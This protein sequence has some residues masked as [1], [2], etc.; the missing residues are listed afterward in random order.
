M[1]II[2]L[3]LFVLFISGLAVVPSL[4][5][6]E[7]SGLFSPALVGTSTTNYYFAKPNELTITVDVLGFVQRPGRYEISNSVNLVNLLSLAG[8]A[9]TD[10]TLN[11]V[12][13]TRLVEADGKTATVEI[14][15]NLNEISKLRATDLVLHH[16]DVIQLERA[17]WSSFRDIFSVVVSVA[18]ITS[19][20]AQVVYLTK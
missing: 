1:R 13:L 18:I 17:G 15:V 19:A 7:R 2:R 9:S 16:G 8:G 6:G 14:R 5:Q 11:D 10:G 12:K 4:S 3:I 20:V